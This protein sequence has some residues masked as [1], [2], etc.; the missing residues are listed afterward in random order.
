MITLVDTSTKEEFVFD[1]YEL[2]EP[3]IEDYE[4]P[5]RLVVKDNA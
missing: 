2:A 5:D 3:F 1:N 4:N